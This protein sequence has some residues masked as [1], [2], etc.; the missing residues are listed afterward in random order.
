[1]I[2]SISLHSTERLGVVSEVR[3]SVVFVPVSEASRRSGATVGSAGAIVS[4]MMFLFT[5]SELRAPGIGKRR[6]ALFR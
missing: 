3:L 6:F 4:M 1:M 2:A 5:E